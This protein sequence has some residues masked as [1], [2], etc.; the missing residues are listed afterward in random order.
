MSAVRGCNLPEDL[1]Y[2][3]EK[4][5][6]ARREDGV[7]VVGL[8]DVAQ[9]LAQGIISVTLKRTG[10]SLAKGK[11]LGTVESGKWVGPVPAPVA[12]DITEVNEALKGNPGLVN[13]DPYG[14]GWIAK[15]TVEDWDRDAGDLVTGADG[16]AAY[17]AFLAQE[18]ISCEDA[19]G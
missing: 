6:W 1:Y 5:V 7:V 12:G 13:T 10:R 17:E 11:S 2:F 16:I 18:G 3:V 9:H 4:H 8:S 14:E 19:P 15:L